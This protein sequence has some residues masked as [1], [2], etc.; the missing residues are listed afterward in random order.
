[1]TAASELVHIQFDGLDQGCSCS[2]AQLFG[3]QV[4]S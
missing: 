3:D 1:L 2:I 4:K